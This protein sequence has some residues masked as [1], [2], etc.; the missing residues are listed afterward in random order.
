MQRHRPRVGSRRRG[1]SKDVRKR[2]AGTLAAAETT[3]ELAVA[4]LPRYP[5]LRAPGS[6]VGTGQ[7]AIA[8]AAWQRLAKHRRGRKIPQYRHPLIQRK[9]W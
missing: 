9:T 1:G 8:P 6:A 2:D 4:S 5:L 7:V 3:A